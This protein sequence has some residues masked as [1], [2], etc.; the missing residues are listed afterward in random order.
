M[1]SGVIAVAALA[2]P[3]GAQEQGRDGGEGAVFGMTNSLLGNSV[4]A[5][6]RAAD[7]RI[8]RRGSFPTGGAGSGVLENNATSLILGEGN[9]QS[10]TD[11]GGGDRFLFASNTGSSSI[12]VFERNGAGLRRVE[13]ERSSGGNINHPISLT[14]HSN[15]LYVLNGGLTNCTGGSPTISGFRVSNG[16]QLTAIPGSI[17]PVPGGLLSGCA[18]V[19]F[20]QTGRLLIVSERQTDN[21]ATYQVDGAGRAGPPRTNATTEIGPFG[22]NFTDDNVLL[23]AVNNLALPFAGGATSYGIENDGSLSPL[24]ATAERNGRSDTCWIEITDDGRFAFTANFQTGDISSY[25]VGPDGRLSLIDPVAATVNA[26]LPGSFYLALVDSGLLYVLDTNLT[27]VVGY[28]ID[29]NGG[30]SE[31][32]RSNLGSLLPGAFGLAAT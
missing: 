22:M 12:T 14:L 8:E 18:Q 3:A 1:L 24:S 25:R 5:F 23:T 28:R 21:L 7:G 6:R 11:L 4:T 29:G 16:G 30:L 27:T 13:I 10:P 19:S 17:Q 32:N 2:V 15:V 9:Q 26:P 31:I 20:D